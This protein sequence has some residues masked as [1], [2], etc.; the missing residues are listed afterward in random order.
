VTCSDRPQEGDER[1][2]GHTDRQSGV[3][4]TASL[5]EMKIIETDTIL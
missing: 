5:I 4:A 2:H 3:V 1:R